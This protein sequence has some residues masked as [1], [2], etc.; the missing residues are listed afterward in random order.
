MYPGSCLVLVVG[1]LTLFTLDLPLQQLSIL[2]NGKALGWV[3]LHLPLQAASWRMA[4]W[5]LAL[6]H[7]T[8]MGRIWPVLFWP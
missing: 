7:G 8:P 6:S 2:L 3:V 5:L 4:G 1:I